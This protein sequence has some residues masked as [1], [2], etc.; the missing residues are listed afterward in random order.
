MAASKVTAMWKRLTMWWA[1]LRGDGRR[2][3]L[4]LRHPDAPMWLK[5]AT[6]VLVLYVLSPIDIVPD[7]LPLLG[8]IDDVL[9]VGFG[10]RWLLS[11]LPG[12]IRA[13]VERQIGARR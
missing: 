5:V 7:T 9:I 3:W 2:L 6:G 12:H 8:W 1:L 11:R 10:M 4:A 13:E